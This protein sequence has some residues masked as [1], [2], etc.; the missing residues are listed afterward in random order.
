M[1]VCDPESGEDL[2]RCMAK[3][4]EFHRMHLQ[5]EFGFDIWGQIDFYES[6]WPSRQSLYRD[7]ADTKAAVLG[8]KAWVDAQEKER[9]LTHID[10][11]CDNFLFCEDGLQLTDWEYAGMQDPHTDLAMFAVYSAFDRAKLD[12]LIDLYFEDD[13]P[14]ETRVKIYCYAAACGLLWSNW[15]EYKSSLGVEF[16]EYSLQQ[17]RAAKDYSRL[18]RKEINLSLRTVAHDG[19]AIRS[20][21]EGGIQ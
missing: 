7:Y 11:V 1:R 14:P 13:C 21:P 10:A 2:R 19:V 17:Y 20:L 4:R 12:H 9:C 15:C 16:G 5:V 6:L 3:L 8:L 18:A